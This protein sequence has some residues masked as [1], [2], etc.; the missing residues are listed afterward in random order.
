MVE[1]YL[2]L[3]W[4]P[5]LNILLKDPSNTSLTS[6]ERWLAEARGSAFG[7]KPTWAELL[8]DLAQ[9]CPTMDGDILTLYVYFSIDIDC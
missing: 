2:S 8:F 4:T 6:V 1:T 7:T 5:I 9:K 3:S